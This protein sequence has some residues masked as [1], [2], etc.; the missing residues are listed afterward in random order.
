MQLLA[1]SQK[2]LEA[3]LAA[4]VVDGSLYARIDRPARLIHFGKG[5]TSEQAMDEWS[6]S[7][8]GVLDLVR[9]AGHLISKEKMVQEARA[10]AMKAK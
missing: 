9:E 4:L 10:K 2:E 8:E 5:T 1:L 7:I 6:Q 3:E